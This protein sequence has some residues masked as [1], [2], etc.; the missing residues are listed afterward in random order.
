M[1]R[2]PLS[3]VAA[4]N[5]RLLCARRRV[6]Q[7]HIADFLGMS[8]G[9]VNDRFRY[10]TPWTVDELG[11]I[12]GLFDVPVGVLLGEVAAPDVMRGGTMPPM[13]VAPSYAPGRRVPPA[14]PTLPGALSQAG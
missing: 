14:E 7:S 5:V 13:V 2:G 1:A 9:Q 6:A 11:K 10:R 8:R 12:A 4:D 3:Y